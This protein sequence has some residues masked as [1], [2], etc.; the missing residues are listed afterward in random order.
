MSIT[1]RIKAFF[2]LLKADK[3]LKKAIKSADRM[4]NEKGTRYYVIP[5]YHHKL[6]VCNWS[7]IKRMRKS[8]MFSNKVTQTD[9]I[10]ESFYYTTD[11]FGNGGLTDRQK[12]QKRRAW[13]NYVAQV[14]RLI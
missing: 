3:E 10:M 5:D 2:I 13:L 14:R 7:D 4:N 9:F 8:G 11:R 6:R 1:K 12:K